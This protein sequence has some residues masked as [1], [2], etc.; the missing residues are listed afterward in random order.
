MFVLAGMFFSLIFNLS[1]ATTQY[2]YCKSKEFKGIS[3][4]KLSSCSS[5]KRLYKFDEDSKSLKRK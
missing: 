3:K 5:Y 1:D 2:Q 4:D